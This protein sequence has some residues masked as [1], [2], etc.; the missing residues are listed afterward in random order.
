MSAY[1]N[2]LFIGGNFTAQIAA[3]LKLKQHKARDHTF[4]DVVF[5]PILLKQRFWI[6]ECVLI[7]AGLLLT[8]QDDTIVFLLEPLHW[9]FLCETV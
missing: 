7:N 1:I 2:K 3:S 8:V 6:N 4:V 5:Y 9:I